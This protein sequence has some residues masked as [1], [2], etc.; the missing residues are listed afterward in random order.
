MDRD[1]YLETL[2]SSLDELV[3][4]SKEKLKELLLLAHIEGFREGY[5]SRNNL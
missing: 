3:I 4:L 1:K 5:E 2:I